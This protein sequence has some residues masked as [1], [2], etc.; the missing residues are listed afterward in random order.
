MMLDGHINLYFDL[1]E[2]VH[3]KPLLQ[4]CQLGSNKISCV[5][6]FLDGIH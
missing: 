2:L 6:S 1:D 5:S 3:Q 4:A